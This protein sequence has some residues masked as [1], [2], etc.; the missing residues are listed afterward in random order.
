M[1]LWHDDIRKPPD[2]S[3]VWA[4]TNREAI[5]ALLMAW[6][7]HVEVEACSLDHDLGLEGADENMAGAHL[8][9]GSSPD[10]DGVDLVKAMVAL[11]LVPARV[12]IHSMNPSGAEWMAGMLRGLS[13][14]VVTVE[15][16][17]VS[18]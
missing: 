5:M 7:E 11:R 12:T 14:A 2:E 15:P 1:K 13:P 17:V 3:W 10:G 8:A 18:V 6:G 4:R 16:Y 9:R